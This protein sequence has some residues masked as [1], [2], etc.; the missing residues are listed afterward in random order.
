M[1]ECEGESRVSLSEDERVELEGLRIYYRKSKARYEAA[2]KFETAFMLRGAGLMFLFWL[3]IPYFTLDKNITM[4]G[5][6]SCIV[7]GAL[8]AYYGPIKVKKEVVKV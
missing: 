4:F 5:I 7:V 8:S 2:E 6:F 3:I 1:S